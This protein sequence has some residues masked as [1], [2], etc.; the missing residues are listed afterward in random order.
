MFI[1]IKQDNSRVFIFN[2]EIKKHK[3]C[4]N[5][6]TAYFFLFPMAE[7]GG[8]V[9][10]TWSSFAYFIH[11][12]GFLQTAFKTGYAGSSFM[13]VFLAYTTVNPFAP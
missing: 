5:L 2:P 6:V 8:T 3:S 10:K 4:H 13:P 7:D 1:L 9:L 11:G 12:N